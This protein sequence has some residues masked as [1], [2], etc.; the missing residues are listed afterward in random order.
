MAIDRNN[1]L[2]AAQKYLAT[3]KLDK[4]IVEYEKLVKE[5]P[6]DARTL[7]KLGDIYTRKGAAREAAAT[8]RKVAEQY[9]AQGFFLKAVAVYKQI[10]KLDPNQLDAWEQ[11]AEM[12]ESLS[13]VS[14]ALATWEQVAEA[15]RAASNDARMINALGRIAKLDAENVAATIKHAE[16]LSKIKRVTEAVEAF[17]RGAALLRKQGRLDDYVKVAERLLFHQNDRTD[18]ILELA[19]VYLQ[20]GSAKQALAHLQAAFAADA[21]HVPTLELLAEAF[22]AIQQAPKAVAVY[23]EL[24][25]LHMAA[26]RD[27]ERRVAL[28]RVLELAPADTATRQEL[29]TL[30]PART[31]SVAEA[32][33]VDFPI[34][35]DSVAKVEPAAPPAQPLG[36]E[37]REQAVTR[38][39]SECQVFLRY[40]LT[41]KVK[42]QLQQVLQLDPE[43]VPAHLKLKEIC[44]K[45]GDEASAVRHLVAM[46]D[47]LVEKDRP[48]ALEYL[49]EAA[50]F[51]PDN[52]EV[53]ERLSAL[54]AMAA[55]Q[56][57]AREDD[58]VIFLDDDEQEEDE[59][60]GSQVLD[61]HDDDEPE[62]TFEDDDDGPVLAL[63]DDDEPLL[64][65]EDA[66]EPDEDGPALELD[67]DDDEE[68]S[69]T[70]NDDDEGPELVLDAE[71]EETDVHQA[72][73]V[74]RPQPGGPR[75]SAVPTRVSAVPGRPSV[76]P[77]LP[78]RAGTLTLEDEPEEELPEAVADALEE[79]GFYMAQGEYEEAR[80]TLDDALEA[81]PDHPSLLEKLFELEDLIAQSSA[82]DDDQSFAMAEKLAQSGHG[83]GAAASAGPGAQAGDGTDVESVISQFKKGVEKQVDKSDTATHYD[84]GIAYMEMG[85]HAEAIEAFTLCLSD[86]DKLCTVHAMIGTSHV[87]KG[88]MEPAIVHFKKALEVPTVSE[89]EE[90]DLWFEIGNASELLGKLT[91]ALVYYE[92]VEERNPSFRDVAERIE[93]LGVSKS[94]NQEEEE[95][96]D[97][98]DNMILKE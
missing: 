28:E 65:L 92:K 93:R 82:G 33:D 78:S 47:A 50:G 94:S 49:A 97:L 53:R 66:L 37:T 34:T 64:S 26:G 52:V 85:L 80:Q 76:V 21:K 70:M 3:G 79:A 55:E 98:F 30:G 15:F 8:Y 91:D 56:G 16:A 39:M 71:D 43:H 20:K 84:L 86:P 72:P 7:L 61:D 89:A 57:D 13:L 41:A 77:A 19:R 2:K 27:A 88:D 69:L 75:V 90:V 18:V 6:K 5:D 38:L 44:L 31:G 25:R 42:K 68:P 9:A 73:T 59:V 23:K 1:T 32:I 62:A 87:S 95:F 48:A 74:E 22:L 54:E 63:E 67:A 35:D 14:D 45:E 12:Y 58:D 96:D 46:A 40:G 81:T 24:S 36:G 4:A 51:E 60:T 17:E 11:L 83:T 29:E 10:L